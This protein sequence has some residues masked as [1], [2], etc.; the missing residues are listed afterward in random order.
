MRARYCLKYSLKKDNYIIKISRKLL[1]WM[2]LYWFRL[3]ICLVS[4]IVGPICNIQPSFRPSSPLFKPS[5]A[6]DHIVTW[7]EKIFLRTT[8]AKW[9]GKMECRHHHRGNRTLTLHLPLRLISR[10]FLAAPRSPSVRGWTVRPAEFLPDG[11]TTGSS[12]SYRRWFLS[13][14][15]LTRCNICLLLLL[16]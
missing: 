1:Y 6:G 9:E 12:S 14:R 4:Q 8:G 11:G 2:L 3:V 15:A 7:Y 13:N 5:L 16:Q 10:C